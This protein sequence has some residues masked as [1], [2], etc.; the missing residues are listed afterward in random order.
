MAWKWHETVDVHKWMV[1]GVQPDFA[2]RDPKISCL[3]GN[4]GCHVRREM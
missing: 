2:A 1:F 4:E 3:N